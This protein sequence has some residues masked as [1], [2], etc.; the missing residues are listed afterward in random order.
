MKVIVQRQEFKTH[1]FEIPDG[2]KVDSDEYQEIVNDYDWGNSSIEH[3]V[4]DVLQVIKEKK[5]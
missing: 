3:A 4:E 5:Q 2:V 1:T